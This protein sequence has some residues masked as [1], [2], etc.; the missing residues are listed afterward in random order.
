MD[1]SPV[2]TASGLFQS[3][4]IATLIEPLDSRRT[5]IHGSGILEI[6]KMTAIAR[7]ISHAF[8]TASPERIAF[9]QI[10]MF[11]GA[12]LLVSMILLSYGLD[13][14]PGFF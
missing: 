2:T 10:M 12:A 5:Q 7:V 8:H 11:C 1:G 9:K 4:K 13:L 6:A 14:S 3:E